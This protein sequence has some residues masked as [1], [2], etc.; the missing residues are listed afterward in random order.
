MNSHPAPAT[1]VPLEH[2]VPHSARVGSQESGVPSKEPPDDQ[3]RLLSLPTAAHIPP[4]T[5]AIEALKEIVAN[6]RQEVER[7]SQSIDSLEANLAAL[8]KLKGIRLGLWLISLGLF[9]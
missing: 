4:S 9:L 2:P 6:L 1:P 5:H 3:P 8:P 7:Q